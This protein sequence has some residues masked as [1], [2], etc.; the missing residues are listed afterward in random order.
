MP[1][2]PIFWRCGP[3]K[4]TAMLRTWLQEL[5]LWLASLPHLTELVVASNPLV[6]PWASIA[7][8]KGEDQVLRFIQSATPVMDLA[9]R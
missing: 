4:K 3:A 8:V 9:G 2:K 5:P 6:E 1:S 7:R